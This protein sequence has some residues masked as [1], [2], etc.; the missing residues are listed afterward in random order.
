MLNGSHAAGEGGIWIKY[1]VTAASGTRGAHET[2]LNRR[3]T[4]NSTMQPYSTSKT[5]PYQSAV[6]GGRW[7][8]SQSRFSRKEWG[9]R[10]TAFRTRHELPR[11]SLREI[12]SPPWSLRASPD[13]ASP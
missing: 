3:Y 7:T 12:Q 11:S 2:L 10:M 8:V 1:L 4:S 6:Q 13:R 9:R 5:L